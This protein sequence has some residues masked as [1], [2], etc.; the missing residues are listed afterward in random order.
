MEESEKRSR[1]Q[2]RAERR[3]SSEWLETL[4]K[5]GGTAEGLFG[6][7]G[8]LAEGEL[9]SHLGYEEHQTGTA[10]ETVQTESRPVTIEV[11]RD[12]AG[13]FE[14]KLIPKHRR[15]LEGFDDSDASVP[16]R[17]ASG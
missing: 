15:R 10:P 11:P 8:V 6:P 7:G 1:K 3:V 12:R 4:M 2:K 14:P 17:I 13:T 9:T 16:E 5:A